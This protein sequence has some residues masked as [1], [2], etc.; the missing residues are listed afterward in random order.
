MVHR[1][2]EQSRMTLNKNKCTFFST[3]VKLL[4]QILSDK[5]DPEK[6]AAIWQIPELTK[7]KTPLLPFK[8]FII[9][10]WKCSN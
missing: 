9:I 4:G 1:K 7:Q 2:L 6:V 3:K 5:E 10:L 8:C